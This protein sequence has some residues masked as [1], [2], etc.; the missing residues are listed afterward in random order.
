MSIRLLHKK[1]S[2]PKKTPT[3][4]QLEYGELAI[5]YAASAETFSIKN[6]E[7]EV[8]TFPMYKIEKMSEDL[9][10][11]SG[12][13]SANATSITNEVTRAT[14]S[15][16]VIQNTITTIS[17]NLSTVSGSLYAFLESEKIDDT[18][19]TL[20]EIQEFIENNGTADIIKDINAINENITNISRET[21]ANAQGINQANDDILT[22]QSTISSVSGVIKTNIDTL[23][24]SVSDNSVAIDA[25][26]GAIDTNITNIEAVSGAV[27]ANTE[28]IEAVSGKADTNIANIEAIS[29]SVSA[30][31][32]AVE[33]VSTRLRGGGTANPHIEP[34]KKLTF[35]YIEDILPYFQNIITNNGLGINTNNHHMG[36]YRILIGIYMYNVNFAVDI[37]NKIATLTICGTLDIVNGELVTASNYSIAECQCVY[38]QTENTQEW[39]KWKIVA[40]AEKSL[41]GK[42]IAF[43]G[44]S[45]CHHA[46]GKGSITQYTDTNKTDT[47]TENVGYIREQL[48][49]YGANIKS[50]AVEGSGFLRPIDDKTIYS[51]ASNASVHDI[52]VIWAPT[53]DWTMGTYQLGEFDDYQK[54]QKIET[55][56]GGLNATISTLINKN[57]KAK[58]YVFLPMKAVDTR[59]FDLNNGKYGNAMFDVLTPN[60]K[61][62]MGYTFGEYINAVIKVCTFRG[63]AVVDTF[64]APNLMYQAIV[65]SDTTKL[66]WNE[67]L[68]RSGKDVHMGYYIHPRRAAYAEVWGVIKK[69]LLGNYGEHIVQ[70]AAIYSESN[71]LTKAIET[72]SGKT[73]ANAEAIEALSGAIDTNIANIEA[74]NGNVQSLIEQVDENEEVITV[75]AHQLA[76]YININ[77]ETIASISGSVSG[78]SVAIA[79]A[80]SGLTDNIEAVS[81]KA[82]VNAEAIE[83][84]NADIEAVNSKVN[85][86][87][88][89]IDILFD[90]M[91]GVNTTPNQEGFTTL[92]HVKKLDDIFSY[93]NE[94]ITDNDGLNSNLNSHKG[95]YRATYNSNN[96]YWIIF[97]FL[98]V[99]NA[100][101]N[102]ATITI[103]GYLTINDNSLQYSPNYSI[104]ERVYTQ[105]NDTREWSDWKLV[106]SSDFQ[107]QII[108][109]QTAISGLTDNIEAVS[110]KAD[111]NAEAIEGIN[112]NIQTLSKELE[113]VASDFYTFLE[114]QEVD[115]P[116]DT[117]HEI[118]ILIDD[119][120][121]RLTILENNTNM[122][123]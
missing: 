102:V 70:Q 112:T 41:V 77:A 42:S 79:E 1:S 9:S 106:S 39:S 119:L 7:N 57:K 22:L 65:N 54:D 107:E 50:Y 3:S 113:Q 26:S 120:T 5:N 31:T 40:S 12:S 92:L 96:V 8:V 60:W 85:T 121:T 35:E 73:D 94:L 15:E 114:D 91:R 29:G 81:G 18:V 93:F 71:K 82:D 58:I 115:D 66:Y 63:V 37:M 83:G 13:V 62:K 53:N 24:G 111:V 99:K 52:Y 101:I 47:I 2:T 10:V 105:T 38:N 90:Y 109:N 17:N 11:L 116:V 110:G 123:K 72:V 68:L 118:K 51:Q 27:D 16:K 6:S 4:D 122:S 84:I 64:S 28:A 21:I 14:Q 59:G 67:G 104:V 44:G 48:E 74:I 25:L 34:F 55:I 19:D 23:S 20:K 56:C 75:V 46:V 32:I 88:T 45:M 80:I 117:L 61:N 103:C 43:F 86:N 69:S 87:I 49:Y 95:T 100:D 36:E 33:D 78:N 108:N 97:G 89:D 98:Y 76:N 30:N